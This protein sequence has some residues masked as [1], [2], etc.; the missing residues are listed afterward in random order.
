MIHSDVA[1]RARARRALVRNT[2]RGRNG[3]GTYE[4]AA[5]LRGKHTRTPEMR[6]AASVQMTGN[7][8][9]AMWGKARKVG[10]WEHE[11][12]LRQM[13]ELVRAARLARDVSLEELSAATGIDEGQ[14]SRIENGKTRRTVN[15]GPLAGTI[16]RIALALGV[17]PYEVMP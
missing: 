17:R 6:A 12:L 15:R 1:Q 5:S 7:V 9:R 16:I 14:L 3:I 4:R 13:G 10:E 8:N 2:G 11:V